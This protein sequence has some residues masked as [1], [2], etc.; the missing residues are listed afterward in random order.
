MSRGI[1]EAELFR[2]ER[3]ELETRTTDPQSPA[4]GERW[5]RTDLDSKTDKLAELRW[6]DGSNTNG[7]NVVAPG[8]TDSGVE[9]VLRIQTPNGAGV[10]PAISPPADAA[11]SSQRLR[12]DGADHGLG[13]SRIRD[14]VVYNFESGDTSEWDTV[15]DLRATA[16]RA[17]NGSY[18]GASDNGLSGSPNAFDFPYEGDAVEISKLTLWYYEKS[19]SAGGGQRF[20][21]PNDNVI[22]GI[23]S[24]NPQLDV[25]DRNGVTLVY[26]PNSYDDAYSSW[27]KLKIDFYWS[28]NQYDI[29][30][31][32]SANGETYSES[33]RPLKRGGGIRRL[34]L[35]NYSSSSWQDGSDLDMFWDDIELQP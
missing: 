30:W 9:E 34:T 3:V 7:I 17:Y 23:A 15:N 33:G 35:E 11:Y 27:I 22:L 13:V 19:N 8:S 24:D 10:I 21:G 4:P 5:L 32:N 29:Y 1:I 12:H 2:T 26:D 28:N 25:D 14:S 18:S 31:E 20:W 6:H 16:N